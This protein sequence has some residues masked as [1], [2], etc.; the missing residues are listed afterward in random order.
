MYLPHR[1]I[2]R[3]LQGEVQKC[4]DTWLRQGI[5]RPSKSLYASQVVIVRKKTSE[6]RLCVDYRKLNSI[7]VRDAFPLPR[8][9]EALQA[10]HNGQWFTSFDLAQG[11]LQMPVEEADIPKTAFRAGSSGLYEF[12]YAIR[13]VQ[14][15]VQFLSPHGNVSRRS[16]IC[17]SP[18]IPRGHLY[19]CCQYR[20]NAGPY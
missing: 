11:Y 19:I 3:Q 13:V 14:L 16:A 6:I 9:D 15:W 20:Q 10:V 17:Y 5:I 18:A 1:T 2:P 8:I 4:L 12:T 7:V